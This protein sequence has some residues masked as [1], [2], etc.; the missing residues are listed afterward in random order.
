MILVIGLGNPGKEYEQTRHNVGFR[1][2]DALLQTQNRDNK[3]HHHL[4]FKMVKKFAAA[5][6]QIDDWLLV[7]PQT[8]MNQSGEAVSRLVRFY[9]VPLTDLWVVHDDL[10]IRLGDYKIQFGRGPKV[11]R[12]VNSIERS[13]GE[14]AFWRVRIGIDKRDLI[15]RRLAQGEE[16]VLKPFLTAE[17]GHVQE[18]IERVIIDIAERIQR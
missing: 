4:S 13:L 8:Y 9:T 3:S 11:H 12:G 10:D 15:N 14:S 5:L 18:V 1:V 16:Y 7:K 2:V 6:A 17:R